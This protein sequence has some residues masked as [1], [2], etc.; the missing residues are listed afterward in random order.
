MQGWVIGRAS[1]WV[2]FAWSHRAHHAVHRAVPLRCLVVPRSDRSVPC[3]CRAISSS[4]MHHPPGLKLSTYSSTSISILHSAATRPTRRA[5]SRS[6]AKGASRSARTLLPACRQ[7]GAGGSSA[8][9]QKQ[10]GKAEAGRRAG[11]QAGQAGREHRGAA[12]A[13][14]LKPPPG[15]A[16]RHSS[17]GQQAGQQACHPIQPAATATLAPSRW[18]CSP[19]HL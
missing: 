19:T 16:G 1:G 3:N 2:G 4:A 13:Q 8:V 15:Q 7:A 14:W 9:T 17:A 10:P 5:A 18:E 11:G 6:A 12:A